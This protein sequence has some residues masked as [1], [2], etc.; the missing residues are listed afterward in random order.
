V[1]KGLNLGTGKITKKEMQ[2]VPHHLLDVASPKRAFSASDF[3]RLGSIAIGKILKKGRVPM[4]ALFDAQEKRP[5]S[6]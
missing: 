1:Y 5:C 3:E 4:V 6:R 2:G